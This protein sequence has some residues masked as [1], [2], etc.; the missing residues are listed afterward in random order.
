VTFVQTLQL[1]PQVQA[2]WSA[3][4]DAMGWTWRG[5]GSDS[6]TSFEARRWNFVESEYKGSFESKNYMEACIR[7]WGN[8]RD[9]GIFQQTLELIGTVCDFIRPGFVG[10]TTVFNML[11]MSTLLKDFDGE[12]SECNIKLLF[13][14]AVKFFVPTGP[15]SSCD[16]GKGVRT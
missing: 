10:S 14:E 5:C 9:L 13:F 1:C 7:L 3:H 11:R 2:K 12:I 15:A 8:L 4:A 16:V 6:G